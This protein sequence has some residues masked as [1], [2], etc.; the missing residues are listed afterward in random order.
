MSSSPASPSKPIDT[1][2]TITP[3]KR[4]RA[5]RTPRMV[6]FMNPAP[7]AEVPHVAVLGCLESDG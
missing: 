7:V 2:V 3:N 6:H 1:W 4:M 5:N